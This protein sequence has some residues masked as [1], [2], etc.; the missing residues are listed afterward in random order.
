MDHLHGKGKLFLKGR[1]P[2][3]S[4]VV[5]VPLS[6]V[7][8]WLK[9]VAHP[10]L[11]IVFFFQWTKFTIFNPLTTTRRYTVAHVRRILTVL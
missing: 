9:H 1:E 7:V 5:W 11:E 3:S 6:R 4:H 2:E 10:H 8:S